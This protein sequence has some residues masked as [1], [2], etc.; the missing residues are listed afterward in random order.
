MSVTRGTIQYVRVQKA[1]YDFFSSWKGFLPWCLADEA[2]AD[3]SSGTT[4][5]PD[6]ADAAADDDA[7][8]SVA[9]QQ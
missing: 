3:A 5:G 4:I 9:A 6:A 1:T 2:D 8:T 7:P